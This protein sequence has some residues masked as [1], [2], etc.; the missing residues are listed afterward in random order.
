M[1]TE[2]RG[3]QG[4]PTSHDPQA[5]EPG[6]P[7]R[8]G[9]RHDL[10]VAAALAVAVW[11]LLSLTAWDIGLT[12]DEP[13]YMSRA[14]MAARWLGVLVTAPGAALS[15]PVID[16]CW[17]G[18][19][20]HPGLMKLTTALTSRLVLALHLLPGWAMPLTWMRTGTIFW[21]G[22][23]LGAMYLLLRAAGVGRAAS[24]FAPAAVLFMPR[25]FAHAHLAALD[26][27]ALAT[28]FLAVAA[29]WWAL[30][31]SDRLSVVLA[32][33]AFGT[34]IA[35]KLNG[36]FVPVVV[37]P[38]ALLLR[39][40]RAGALALSYALLGTAVF[41]LTWPWL[42]HDTWTRLGDYLAFHWRH[43][44]I[45]VMYFGRIYT[46]APWHYPLVMTGITTPPL[47]LLMALAGLGGWLSLLG[48]L[49][50]GK[51]ADWQPVR[52]LW[53]LAGWALAVNLAPN[54]LPSSPK[55]GGVRLFLPAMAWLGVLAALAAGRVLHRL[56]AA[57]PLPREQGWVVSA[58]LMALLLLPSVAEVSHCH[59]Y[60]LSAYN[61]LIGGLPGA[62]RRGF[63]PTYW[64]D[65][66]LAAALWLSDNAPPGATVWI[67]PQGMESVVRMYRYLGP[68]R[69]DLRTTS[70]NA[71]FAT[72]DFIVSQ[73]KPTEFS[74]RVR[75]LL[76]T[77]QPLWTDGLDGVPL[78]FVWRQGTAEASAGAPLRR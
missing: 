13:I 75:Q 24:L 60:C 76:A 39:P 6:K 73:N 71:A 51:P 64:G 37:L 69:P 4:Q 19:D 55:Y 52:R 16:E 78:V 33:L 61:G 34:A 48:R 7:C 9:P 63:E 40:R 43:W 5:P 67:E 17:L 32:G 65:T 18:K 54:M 10:A 44:E 49:S 50:K 77:R 72:A 21:M 46:L 47:T 20:Q 14:D 62:A 45:G 30:E 15:R 57:V 42:W 26:A 12:Y 27:P 74:R 31:R 35:T 1:T 2:P 25:V 23:T 58:V 41:F 3:Q 70:G 56:R 8:T 22:I 53:L 36:F 59:P 66:Y 38:Y 68:L 28:C 29:A 11:A